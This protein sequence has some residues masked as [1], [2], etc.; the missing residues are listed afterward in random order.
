[1]AQA[2][3]DEEY[4]RGLNDLV[5]GLNN[6]ATAIQDSCESLIRCLKLIQKYMISRIEGILTKVQYPNDDE[7][8]YKQSMIYKATGN[9][10]FYIVESLKKIGFYKKFFNEI[11]KFVLLDEDEMKD[12]T[13]EQIRKIE[14][15]VGELKG[16]SKKALKQI[17]E[18][19]F[20]TA[21]SRQIKIVNLYE[22]SEANLKPT[23]DCYGRKIKIEVNIAPNL[24]I[25]ADEYDLEEMFYEFITNSIR[26]I[27][28]LYGEDRIEDGE[29]EITARK[30]KDKIIIDVKDNGVGLNRQ[31]IIKI[32]EKKGGLGQDI[33][34]LMDEQKISALIF[35]PWFTTTRQ[36]GGQGLGIIRNN[37]IRDGGDINVQSEPGKGTTFTITLPIA[38]EETVDKRVFE[39]GISETDIKNLGKPKWTYRMRFE[40][41]K[42]IDR[43]AFRSP[44]ALDEFIINAFYRNISKTP[45][46]VECAFFVGAGNTGMLRFVVKQDSCD[47]KDWKKIDINWRGFREKGHWFL[48]DTKRRKKIGAAREGNGLSHV[49]MLMKHPSL[50]IYMRGK[51]APFELRTEFYIKLP[52]GAVGSIRKAIYAGY[53]KQRIRTIGRAIRSKL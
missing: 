48:I 37:I 16:V 23:L 22:W 27:V 47:E 7:L 39:S 1:M 17:D 44:T 19:E 41:E 15:S 12:F 36:G 21:A 9:Y 5:H 49:G 3:S 20:R 11:S 13:D 46:Y 38:S 31:E 2:L 14:E 50:L 43:F 4:V 30:V 28:K 24:S 26:A 33:I 51:E 35:E 8:R 32:A 25:L 6:K 40:T 45:I 34:F 42:D 52:I 10:K 18:F 29:I 53:V